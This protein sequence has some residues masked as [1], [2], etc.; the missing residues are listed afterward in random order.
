[1]HMIIVNFYWKISLEKKKLRKRLNVNIG[2]RS[3]VLHIVEQT[4]YL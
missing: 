4:R 1:M 3:V 2:D